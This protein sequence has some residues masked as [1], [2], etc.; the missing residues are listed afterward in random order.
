MSR[1]YCPH[2]GGAIGRECFNVQ[3]CG[4]ITR[5]IAQEESRQYGSDEMDRLRSENDQIRKEKTDLVLK[6][7]PAMDA[8][9]RLNALLDAQPY[10]NS[11]LTVYVIR[12]SLKPSIG[13]DHE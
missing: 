13:A 12:A 7:Y 8:I 11:T 1:D 6:A 10:A 3:E 5:Q 9:D 4:E 2:C